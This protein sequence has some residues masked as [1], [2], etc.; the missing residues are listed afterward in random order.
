MI[1]TTF[2][3]YNSYNVEDVIIFI[4]LVFYKNILYFADFLI[5]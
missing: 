3:D 1:F 4:A 2:T 5:G